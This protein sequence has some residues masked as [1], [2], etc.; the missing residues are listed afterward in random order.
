MKSIYFNEEHQSFREHVRTFIER[1]VKPQA[2]QWET[3]RLIPKS[4]WKALGDLGYLGINHP[5]AYGG[6]AADFFYSVVFLEEVARAGYAGLS[7]AVSVHEYMATAHLSRVGSHELKQKYLVPA[8]AGD[9]LGALAISEPDTGSDVAKITTTAKLDGD[10][11]VVSGAKMFITNGTSADFVTTAVKTHLEGKPPGISLLIIDSQ[12]PGFS[13][14]KLDKIGWHS[15]DTAIL[16]FDEVRVP[17]TNIIGEINK[18]FS[19]IMES[20]QLERLVGA[21]MAIGGMDAAV[22]TTL[23]YMASRKAFN[24]KLTRFQAIRHRMVDLM[25]EIESIRQ[26][27]YHTCWLYDQGEVPVTECSMAK[28]KATELANQVVDACLQFHGGYGYMEEYAIARMYRDS[29]AGTIVGGTSEIMREIIA[30]TCL[31]DVQFKS[32]YQKTSDVPSVTPAELFASLDQR[33]KQQMAADVDLTLNFELKGD[34]GGSFTVTVRDGT[35]KVSEGLS[36][37]A[38]CVVETEASTYVQIE[39]GQMAAESAFMSGQ[40]QVSDIPSMML[41]GQMFRRYGS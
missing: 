25:T 38:H 41:F 37:D 22:A 17:V 9:Q 29:R 20:F 21:V 32:A 18:G 24:R 34:G 36:Q 30:K 11:F 40:V 33:F 8:I 13:A 26:F 19:Y 10:H 27:T 16:S 12:S 2:D 1:E 3:D 31:D 23:E 6:S 35:C 39:T 5:E 15:S 4:L 14:S 28:M 7:A